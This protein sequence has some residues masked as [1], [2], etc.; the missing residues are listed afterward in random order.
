MRRP[1]PIGPAQRTEPT[2]ALPLSLELSCEQLLSAGARQG[3]ER[4]GC[5][6]AQQEERKRSASGDQQDGQQDPRG[7][8][9]RERAPGRLL[10]EHEA[11]LVASRGAGRRAV[12]TARTARGGDRHTLVVQR[13]AVLWAASRASSARSHPRR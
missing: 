5:G 9:P 4:L 3:P 1:V 8:G 7:R 6:V 13:R 2:S 10:E 11:T 12:A